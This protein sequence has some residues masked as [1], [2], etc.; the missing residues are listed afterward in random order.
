MHPV[1]SSMDLKCATTVLLC[2][3]KYLC[4]LLFRGLCFV[5]VVVAVVVVL[6]PGQLV[7]YC[8]SYYELKR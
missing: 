5:V 4:Y 2:I 7:P 1:Q 6:E 3:D 8:I